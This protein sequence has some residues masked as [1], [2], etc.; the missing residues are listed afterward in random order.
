MQSGE[1]N[2]RILIKRL[3]K[4]SDGFG[5]YSSTSSTND[6]IWAKVDYINGEITNRNGKKNRNLEIELIIRKDTADNILVTDL[7]QI[8]NESGSFQINDMYNADY[9]YYTKIKASK[10]S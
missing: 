1:L 5:G 8:E 4:S 3:T 10:R 2:K 7:F 6:T 9:K